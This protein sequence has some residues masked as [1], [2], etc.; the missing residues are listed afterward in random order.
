MSSRIPWGRVNFKIKKSERQ[1]FA[2]ALREFT[3]ARDKVCR[4]TSEKFEHS[5]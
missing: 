2:L 4:R 5:D 3:N 1:D